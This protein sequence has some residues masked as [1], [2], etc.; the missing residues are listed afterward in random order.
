MG[1]GYTHWYKLRAVAALLGYCEQIG[2]R[3]IPR[4]DATK[5]DSPPTDVGAGSYRRM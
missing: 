4:E 3:Q 5:S 2:D 1:S